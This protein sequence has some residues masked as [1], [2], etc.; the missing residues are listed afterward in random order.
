MTVLVPTH[1]LD[2]D[3]A[4][5]AMDGVR[6]CLDDAGRFKVILDLALVDFVDASGLGEI[7][8]LRNEL[9]ACGGTLHV[10]RWRHKIGRVL[11]VAELF[12]VLRLR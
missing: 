2:L 5:P 11:R 7:V 8:R 3:T 9:T 6:T 1:E 12:E 10:D 4:A